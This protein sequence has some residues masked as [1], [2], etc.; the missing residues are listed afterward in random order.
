[1]TGHFCP[2]AGFYEHLLLLS[3]PPQIDS[4]IYRWSASSS[5]PGLPPTSSSSTV[6]GKIGQS[7]GQTWTT[8]VLRFVTLSAALFQTKRDRPARAKCGPR[9]HEDSRFPETNNDQKDNAAASASFYPDARARQANQ[10]STTVQPFIN[11]SLRI[12][13]GGSRGP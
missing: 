8:P 4:A 6:I 1:M 3:L 9:C 7:M 12:R 5:F 11:F 2:K 10:I 13:G